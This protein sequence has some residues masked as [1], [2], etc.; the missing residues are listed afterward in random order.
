MNVCD[1]VWRLMETDD[2]MKEYQFIRKLSNT[3]QGAVYLAEHNK[4]RTHVA[5]KIVHHDVHD[6]HES[7]DGIKVAESVVNELSILRKLS[8]LDS[9]V[10]IFDAVNDQTCFYLITKFEIGGDLFDFLVSNPT[11]PEVFVVTLFRQIVLVVDALH[12]QELCHMDLSLENILISANGQIKLCDFGLARFAKELTSEQGE[13]RLG[14]PKYMSPEIVLGQCFCGY[15]ADIYSLG[16]V[17]FCLLYGTHPYNFPD[18]QSTGFRKI[19]QGNFDEYICF[20]NL[21]GERSTEAESL[22]MTMLCPESQRI[23]MK[24]LKNHAWIIQQI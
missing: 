20:K 12:Q 8:H 17:L 18:F 10:E 9:V 13:V 24:H 3:I 11:L 7:L 16:V 22:L 6:R 14:K 4:S 2:V 23:D 5:V 21:K 15:S 1:P 19:T